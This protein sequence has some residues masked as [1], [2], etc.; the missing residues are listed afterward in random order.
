METI[1]SREEMR[2]ARVDP[3]LQEDLA[4]AIDT[5]LR[6]GKLLLDKQEA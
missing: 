1:S 2:E 6:I 3:F 5:R 4:M